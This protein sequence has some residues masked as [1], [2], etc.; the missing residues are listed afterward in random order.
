MEKGFKQGFH[1]KYGFVPFSQTYIY[2]AVDHTKPAEKG[3][4]TKYMQGTSLLLELPTVIV[5]A[6]IGP[7]KNYDLLTEFTCHEAVGIVTTELR[8]SSRYPELSVDTL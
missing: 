7:D 3:M 2:E 4:Y 5:D 1:T 6:R 8:F